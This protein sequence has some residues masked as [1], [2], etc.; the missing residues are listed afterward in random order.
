MKQKI[1]TSEIVLFSCKSKYQLLKFDISNRIVQ[2]LFYLGNS[3]NPHQ[4]LSNQ[5]FDWFGNTYPYIIFR[6]YNILSIISIY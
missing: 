1:L 3:R 5:I 6:K 2:L 4:E